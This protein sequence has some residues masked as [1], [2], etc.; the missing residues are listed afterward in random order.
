MAQLPLNI[1]CV[2]DNS[3]IRL[4]LS[5]LLTSEGYG[6]LQAATGSQA[7]LQ[8]Q[9]ADLVILFDIGLP[10]MSGFEVCRRI[11]A[12]SATTAPPRIGRKIL[13]ITAL[14]VN[15]MSWMGELDR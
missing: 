11:K 14:F 9:E 15:L 2:D 4:S 8:I 3:D 7:L 10:D 6:V 13:R 12:D 5:L 1:L